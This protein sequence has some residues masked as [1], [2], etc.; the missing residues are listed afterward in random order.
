[1]I[2]RLVPG[3]ARPIYVQIQD[4]IRR[5]IALGTLRAHDPL[6]SLR[7]L[8]GDLRVNP[9]T[10]QLAYRELEREGVIYTRR[11]EGTYVARNKTTR[12]EHMRMAKAVAARALQD[13]YRHGITLVQL[14]EALRAQAG[15][16]VSGMRADATAAATSAAHTSPVDEREIHDRAGDRS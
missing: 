16:E 15:P 3:D 6:P 1:M 9:N 14:I 13:A 10:V 7:Q 11:G 8:A 2:V 5:S 12:A 4:E